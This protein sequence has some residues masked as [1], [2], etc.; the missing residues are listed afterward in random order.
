MPFEP[1]HVGMGGRPKGT[2]GPREQARRD[3]FAEYIKRGRKLWADMPDP[4]FRKAILDNFPPDKFSIEISQPEPIFIK[5]NL[6]DGYNFNS[7]PEP[8]PSGPDDPA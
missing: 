2:V 6:P 3:L 4:E 7:L 5:F 1:G 8:P